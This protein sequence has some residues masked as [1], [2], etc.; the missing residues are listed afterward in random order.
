MIELLLNKEDYQKIAIFSYLESSYTELVSIKRI[1]K[2]MNLTYFKTTKLIHE[3][4]ADFKE[5]G[6]DD[7][8]YIEK[9]SGMY[10][11]KKNGL[12]S[13][14]RLLWMYGRRSLMFNYL[15]F[16]LKTV[17]LT[18]EKFSETFY[19]SVSTA[20]K[21]KN[22]VEKCLNN[23]ELSLKNEQG[24]QEA[25][26]RF[27]LSQVYYIFF[28]EYEEPFPHT[29]FIEAEKM[30]EELESTLVLP[31]NG[32][33]KRTQV[34]YYLVFSLFRIKQKKYSTTANLYLLED[35][36]IVDTIMIRCPQ[37][38]KWLA[39]AN[40]L[41]TF[42]NYLRTTGWLS[43]ETSMERNYES[44]LTKLFTILEERGKMSLDDVKK[45]LRPKLT[46]LFTKYA[47]H[48]NQIIDSH[49][50]SSLKIFQENYGMFLEMV[51]SFIEEK[52]CRELLGE[53]K[54]NKKFLM[55]LLFILINKIPYQLLE[56]K[57]LVS[58]DFSI[59]C[60]Y[61]EFIARTIENLPFANVVVDFSYSDHTDI[62]L[63]DVLTKEI[64]SRYLIWNSPP[65]AKD[66]EIFGN[67]V[68][69]VK[70]SERE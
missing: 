34:I 68:S 48:K 10:R 33:M 31:K 12:D 38:S 18:L 21:I 20:F 42:V 11:Y 8:F 47:T 57:V 29:L 37:V 35:Q 49:F 9:D 19:I 32:G 6:L 52:E 41:E 63:S 36:K 39:T 58:V 2:Q 55:E 59:G 7:F 53:L 62:Y 54:G 50:F 17:N 1:E 25:Q 14:N 56:K 3:L 66:W 15:D 61:N 4:M 5:M 70:E 67:L 26:F 27:I 45:R 24:M 43:G 46:L 64:D 23:Y 28:K 30:L 22:E 13:L 40:E 69:S 51:H 60:E 44:L 16:F 65:T